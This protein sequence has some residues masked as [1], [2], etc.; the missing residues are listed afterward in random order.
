MLTSPQINFN[1]DIV[2]TLSRV[3]ACLGVAEVNDLGYSLIRCCACRS[4]PRTRTFVCLSD[5][6][7][8][9]FFWI[10]VDRLF[11]LT[12]RWYQTGEWPRK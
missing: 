10:R 2:L 5:H 3:R 4:S 11:I 9:S 1:D 12:V 7:F 6:V 8:F